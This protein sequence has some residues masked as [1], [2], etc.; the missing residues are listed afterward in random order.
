VW[1]ATQGLATG[2]ARSAIASTA[3]IDDGLGALLAVLEQR[4]ALANTLVIVTSDNGWAKGTTYEMGARVPLF[5]RYPQEIAAGTIF[6]ST[7]LASLIDIA[8]T[9]LDYAGV[10]ASAAAA[11]GSDGVSLRTLL[12]GAST[13][14]T[15]SDG[16]VFIEMGFDRAV[17]TAQYKMHSVG[18]GA[19]AN[20]L[21]Q[22]TVASKYPSWHVATQLYDLNAD[23]G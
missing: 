23:G 5:M 22:T 18:E 21:A 7:I 6:G 20:V 15:R 9:V 10:G 16:G 3:W 2:S 1:A 17:V 12:S 4:S 11:Y 19:F 13:L 8:P 14:L